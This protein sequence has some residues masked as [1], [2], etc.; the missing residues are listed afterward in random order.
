MA[1]ATQGCIRSAV[2]T[3]G[4]VDPASMHSTGPVEGPKQMSAPAGGGLHT[5]IAP[6]GM[7]WSVT[8]NLYVALSSRLATAVPV[9]SRTAWSTSVPD[10]A[11]AQLTSP[12]V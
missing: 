6:P 12:P 7:F 2:V 11:A 9:A 1:P 4:A 10:R 3:A 8:Q 5:G